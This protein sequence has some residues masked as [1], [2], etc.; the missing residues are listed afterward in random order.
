MSRKQG[1]V[2]EDIDAAEDGVRLVALQQEGEYFVTQ[3][4]ALGEQFTPLA[5]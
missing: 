4:H 3:L 2:G 5:A 1:P